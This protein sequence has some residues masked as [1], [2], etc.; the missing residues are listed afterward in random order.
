MCTVGFRCGCGTVQG[1]L[2]NAG[3]GLAQGTRAECFCNSCRSAELHLGQPDPR[4]GAVQVYHT[5]PQ[6]IEITAGSAEI[7][8]FRF[9]AK[10]AVRWYAACCRTP[11]FVTAATRRFPFVS[12]SVARVT[13]PK[14]LGPVTAQAFVAKPNGKT[15][16]S[17]VPRFVGGTLLRMTGAYLTGGWRRNPL[18]APDGAPRAPFNILTADQKARLPLRG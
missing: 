3:P 14:G 17:G 7:V 8:N 16:H 6:N 15:G 10:G 18:F 2:K 1:T 11:L 5:L 12:M 13:D 4:P 9:N